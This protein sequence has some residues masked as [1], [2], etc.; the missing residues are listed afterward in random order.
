MKVESAI[1]KQIKEVLAIS[2]RRTPSSIKPE[3]S[4]REDLGLDSL[5]TFELLYD[6][7]K[8]FDLE[9]PNDDLP[10][11]QTLEDVVKY[12]EARVNFGKASRKLSKKTPATSPPKASPKASTAKFKPTKPVRTKTT[13]TSPK[14]RK[15]ETPPKARTTGA[16]NKRVTSKASSQKLP[17]ISKSR[18]KKK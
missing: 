9:I 16:T 18:T 4:L 5:M 15:N 13:P 10:G 17:K 11:L 3:H 12:V 1:G 2:L 6:L 8:A 7:E 14:L